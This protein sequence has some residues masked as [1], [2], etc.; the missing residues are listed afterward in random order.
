MN[1]R[2]AVLLGILSAVL[3]ALAGFYLYLSGGSGDQA[4][5]AEKASGAAASGIVHVRTIYTADAENL[6]RPT[7]IGADENGDFFVTLKDDARVIGFDRDGDFKV[8]WGESGV[9]QGQMLAPVAVLPD[10][11]AN[12]V[13]VIDR[14]RLRVISYN[15]RGDFQWERPVLNPV[16]IASFGDGIAITTFGPIVRLTAEGETIAESGSRG[17]EPGQFD[18]PRSAVQVSESELVVADT[19]NTRLQRVKLSDTAT[20]TVKWVLG[21]PPR[22]QDDPDTVFGVPSGVAKDEEGRIYALDGFR[23]SIAVIDPDSGKTVHTFKDLEGKMDGQFYLPTGIVHLGGDRFAISDTY[24]DRVQIVRL[25]PPGENTVVNRYPWLLWLLPLL[26]L[27]LLLLLRRRRVY[28]TREAL[29]LAAA[30][31]ELRL[32]PA[33]Y[34][35]LLVTGPAAAAYE[36]VVE[37][38]VAISEYLIAI[39]A[40]SDVADEEAA[41]TAASRPTLLRRIL[42]ARDEVICADEPQCTRIAELIRARARTFASVRDE[43]ALESAS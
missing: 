29:D 24:N 6:R 37:E 35:K 30:Q 27:P 34:G 4:D 12:Q 39:P 36:G 16:G 41:I 20:S 31:G 14:A 2:N 9:D 17:Y 32:L 18:Y 25:L 11:L 42:L 15:S 7:G 8:A 3:I 13:Y 10:R 23:H 33:V 40:S 1:R 43:Y 38:G 26:L 19:N 21:A 28:V 5:D 22:F